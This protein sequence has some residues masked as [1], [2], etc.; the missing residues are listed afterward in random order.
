MGEDIFWKNKVLETYKDGIEI[1]KVNSG[2]MYSYVE[3]QAAKT[4]QWIMKLEQE[5]FPQILWGKSPGK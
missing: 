3:T 1:E 2:N 4:F 5:K